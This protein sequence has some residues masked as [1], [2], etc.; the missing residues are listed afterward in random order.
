LYVPNKSSDIA[1][2]L[3]LP[4][5]G[6][7]TESMS[8][9]GLPDPSVQGPNVDVS[10]TLEIVKRGADAASN[11]VDL[12]VDKN[13]PVIP[14]T[15]H[16]KASEYGLVQRTISVGDSIISVDTIGNTSLTDEQR[17]ELQQQ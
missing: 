13:K 1:T 3:E 2:D 5:N 9:D 10:Q 16:T 8:T 4:S 7:A 17:T 14:D 12:V 6:T 15:T 11:V